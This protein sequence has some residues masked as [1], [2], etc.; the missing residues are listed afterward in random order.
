MPEYKLEYLFSFYVGLK[1]PPEVIGPVPEG[2]R[3]NFY[4]TGGCIEA[5]GSTEAFFPSGQTGYCSGGTESVSWM[6]APR[7]RAQMAHLSTRHTQAS[8]TPVRMGMN[9]F[10]ETTYLPRCHCATHHD[11]RLPTRIML[12]ST[13]CSASASVK[14]T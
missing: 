10:C 14:S 2:I 8:W 9:D 12:G 5:P 6:S 4:L 3:A 7:F 11:S 13:D 1:L